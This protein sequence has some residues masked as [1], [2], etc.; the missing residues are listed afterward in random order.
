MS[1]PVRVR[2]AGVFQAHAHVPG[3][4]ALPLDSILLT[5]AFV[6]AAVVMVLGR[7][8]AGVRAHTDQL[9]RIWGPGREGG[10]PPG[11]L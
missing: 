1:A 7:R 8:R 11:G 5:S 3:S 4:K 2:S 9:V 10:G 6:V